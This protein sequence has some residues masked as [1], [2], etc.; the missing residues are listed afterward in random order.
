[1]SRSVFAFSLGRCDPE[2][3]VGKRERDG[4][5]MRTPKGL[6]MRTTSPVSRATLSSPLPR[7]IVGDVVLAWNLGVRLLPRVPGQGRGRVPRMARRVFAGL[8]EL[9]FSFLMRRFQ[10]KFAVSEIS[11]GNGLQRE[12]NACTFSCWVEQRILAL[13]KLMPQ[14]SFVP[15][16]PFLYRSMTVTSR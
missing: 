13:A 5:E 15:R 9:R 8:G 12:S 11:K 6:T 3:R 10:A 1:M 4:K 14:G 2:K 16:M 7:C